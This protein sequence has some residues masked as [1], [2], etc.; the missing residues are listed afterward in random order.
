MPEIRIPLG[1]F[2]NYGERPLNEEFCLRFG[3]LRMIDDWSRREAATPTVDK[4]GGL[5]TA[6]ITRRPTFQYLRSLNS[7]CSIV[8]RRFLIAHIRIK[9][10]D[11]NPALKRRKLGN[12]QGQQVVLSPSHMFHV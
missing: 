8:P 12:N 9:V 7:R 2:F 4:N 10:N 3:H 1:A 11:P 5:P 6:D